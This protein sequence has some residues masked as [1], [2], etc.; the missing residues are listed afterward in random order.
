M[1]PVTIG[2]TAAG[3]AVCPCT[4]FSSTAV[5]AR[6]DAGDGSAITV[7]LRFVPTVAG[8]VTG[9]RF[10]KSAANTGPH[11]GS[12]WTSDGQ[13]LATGTFTNETASGWQILTFTQPV[14]LTVGQTYV[15]SYFAPDG[16]Y[17]AD[18]DAV[19]TG[20]ANGPLQ[21][22]GGGKLLSEV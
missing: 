18:F 14:D 22:P 15:V 6:A 9:V 12:L 11:T 1:D 8:H 21:I 13:R 10:F 16:H 4:A 3:A 5:P 20:W 7:G 19:A 17:A 2:F